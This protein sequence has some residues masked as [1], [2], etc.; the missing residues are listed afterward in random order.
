MIDK[1][2]MFSS[3]SCAIHCLLM[4]LVITLVPVFGLS[5]FVN[6]TFEWGLLVFSAILGVSSLCFGYRKHKSLKAFAYLSSGVMLIV[7]GRLHHSHSS[8]HGLELDLFTLV[9][10]FG[11]I[12]VAASHYLN[13]KLC[14]SCKPC[15]NEGCMH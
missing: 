13:N 10:V 11:S 4:P 3:V 2:G 6:E 12:L 15:Q 5:L 1:V 8:V 9:L 14:G 7:I